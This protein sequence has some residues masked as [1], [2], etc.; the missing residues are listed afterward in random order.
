MSNLKKHRFCDLYTMSSGISSTK[1]QAGHGSPFLSFSTVFNNYFVP[2]ELTDLMSTS[3]KEKETYSIKRGD[4]FLTRTS[5]V[6]DELAMSCVATKDYP[7]ASYSGFLK[8]LRPTQTDVTYSKFMAFYLRSPMFRKTMT[9]NAVMT[10]RASLNEA[11]FSYLDLLL[12]EFDEQVKAGDLLY[13][14]NEKIEINNRINTELEA[15]AKT[16]YD[17]W[18]VQFDFPDTNG[19]PYKAS[20][21][22]MVYNQNLKREIPDGWIDVSL[23]YIISRS[24]T[25][26]NPRNNFKL[27]EGNNYYIT[28]KSINDGKITFDERCDRISDASLKI[29]NQRSDLKVGDIL[30]TSIQPVGETY[31][32]QEKPTN[33]NIN[34]SVFTL[35]FNKERV[36]SEYLYMLLSSQEMKVYTKQCSAGSIHKGIRHSVLKSFQLPYGGLDISRKFTE[37]IS[38]LLKKQSV[39]EQENLQL[40]ELRD[41]LLPMLMNGQVTVKSNT[42]SQGAQHG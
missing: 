10:L 14:L 34:E 18:F 27:G 3:E 29:I 39:L 33:W 8:R 23:D 7:S 28:I 9:N 4:I 36:T 32:I 16:I 15:M 13:L 22:K 11:I 17:Y 1:E 21:G 19:K 6:I 40:C 38:P 35:R 5:E 30:F 20:G 41:W 31:F 2:D 42:E 24:G 12:P 25:G 26:L 37:I